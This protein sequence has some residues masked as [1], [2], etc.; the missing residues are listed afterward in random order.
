[1]PVAKVGDV[2]H[3]PPV[4]YN[5]GMP[6]KGNPTVQVRL[7]K[8]RRAWLDKRA[9]EL[10]ETP[11][12]VLRVLLDNAMTTAPVLVAR[13]PAKSLLQGKGGDG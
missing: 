7:D 12:G 6:G 9:K 11:A 10:G 4:H 13:T 3:L 5:G 2:V 8:E 1:M